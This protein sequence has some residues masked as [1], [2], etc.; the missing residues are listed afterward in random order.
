MIQNCQN[1]KFVLTLVFKENIFQKLN[2][3]YFPNV[4]IPTIYNTLTGNWCSSYRSC[5]FTDAFS[6][7]YLLYKIAKVLAFKA[8]L[9]ALLHGKRRDD[10]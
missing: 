7:W 5:D 9:F 3:R 1:S 8:H 2:S 10:S 4:F 6:K